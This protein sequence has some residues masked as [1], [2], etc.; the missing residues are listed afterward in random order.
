MQGA[1]GPAGS[2]TWAGITDKPTTFA[3]SAHNHA[4][5]DITSGTLGAARLPAQSSM[6]V[7]TPATARPTARTDINVFWVGHVTQ[8]ANALE[9][10]VW[11][12]D[13]GEG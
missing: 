4:A 8:P 5:S 1:T 2:T 7:I 10:D 11:M 13:L 3:P 12:P 6:V 9:G